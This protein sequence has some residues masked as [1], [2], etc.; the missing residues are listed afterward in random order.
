MEKHKCKIKFH[1]DKII[2][3]DCPEKD[4][5]EDIDIYIDD[6]Y[7]GSKDCM[8]HDSYE[9]KNKKMRQKGWRK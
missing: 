9:K 3:S 5:C 7:F 2:C 6:K 4:K 8:S 1:E